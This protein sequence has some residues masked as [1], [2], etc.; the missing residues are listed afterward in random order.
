VEDDP[1]ESRESSEE[2]VPPRRFPHHVQV[3]EEI[4]LPHQIDWPLAEGLVSDVDAVRRLGVPDVAEFHARIL[5]RAEHGG[6][7]KKGPLC[8]GD[9]PTPQEVTTDTARG[10]TLA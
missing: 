5:S 9:D 6:N 10:A 3:A 7:C 2:G 8:G 1:G 4:E